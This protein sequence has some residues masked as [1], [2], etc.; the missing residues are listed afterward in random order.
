[1]S[2]APQRGALTLA[3]GLA[4][5]TGKK[6]RLKAPDGR[7][8]GAAAGE[9]GLQASGGGVS[10]DAQASVHDSGARSSRSDPRTPLPLKNA[11]YLLL[12]INNQNA[13]KPPVTIGT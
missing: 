1:V 4:T 2:Q 5:T 11:K 12:F 8:K 7:K 13:R 9:V 3:L 6:S 10:L